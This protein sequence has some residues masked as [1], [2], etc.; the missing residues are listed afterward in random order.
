M[1][2]FLSMPLKARGRMVGV[3]GA[4]Q[5][6]QERV[7]RDLAEHPASGGVAGGRRHRQRAAIRA[8]PGLTHRPGR[9]VRCPSAADRCRVPTRR[10]S[11]FATGI[12]VVTTVVDG[13]DHAM[14]ANSF[15]SVS[16]DPL[17]VLV[18]VERDDPVPRGGGRQRAV[19]VSVLDGAPAPPRA[20]WPRRAARSRVS[21]TG[22]RHLRA[23]VTGAAV[24][25]G[26][27]SAF[28]CET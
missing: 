16:L 6:H 23:P 27:L 22:S 28:E 14:T 3:L 11:R 20:G 17:L 1:A 10:R 8:R 4:V 2:T 18:C 25:E 7:R 21:S 15:T 26:S 12:T 5:R 13:V 24:V 9:V 19:G